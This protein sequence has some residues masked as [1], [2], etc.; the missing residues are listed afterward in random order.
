MRFTD[1][2]AIISGGSEGMGKAAAVG[3]AKEGASVVITSRSKEKCEAAANEIKAFGGKVLIVPGDITNDDHI[4]SVVD[5]ALKEFG[6]VDILFNYAGG[7]P[8]NKAVGPFIKEDK[9]YW[10]KLI[11]VNLWA[12]IIFCRAAIDPMMKQKYGKIVNTAAMAGKVGA[13]NMVVYSGAKAGVIG[14]TKGLAQEMVPYNINV[15]C[16]CPGP[17]ATPGAEKVIGAMMKTEAAA[18]KGPGGPPPGRPGVIN[19]MGTP[20]EVASA[21][22]YLASDDAAFING[23][24]L[25]VDGGGSMV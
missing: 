22:L 1:K 24:P 25:S 10:D 8:D 3:F 9:T 16:V 7:S 18:G 17:V 2:V 20:W 6:K 12:T 5:K 21:V 15:N 13:A 14:F 11:R 19:R 4:Y 23:Q